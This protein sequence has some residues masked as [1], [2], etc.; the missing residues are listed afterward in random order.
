MTDDKTAHPNFVPIYI[1]TADEFQQMF[2]RTNEQLAG[3]AAA[4]KLTKE[5]PGQV[6]QAL[7][8]IAHEV[9]ALRARIDAVEQALGAGRV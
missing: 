4:R 2:A 9:A 8:T 5:W 6:E 7:V 3:Q 1:P